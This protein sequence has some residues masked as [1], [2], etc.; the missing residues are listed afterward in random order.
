[1]HWDRRYNWPIAVFLLALLA[2]LVYFFEIRDH[3]IILYPQLDSD[4]YHQWAISI[5]E[6][7][8][9]GGSN[10]FFTSPFYAYFLAIIY[11][12]FSPD[13]DVIRLVQIVFG[14]LTCSL[15][16]LIGRK[17]F[18]DKAALLASLL[19]CCYGYFIYINLELLKNTLVV[20]N[21]TLG[22]YL[23]LVAHE[24]QG[25]L[26]W[27]VAG[28]SMGLAVINQPNILL[29]LPVFIFWIIFDKT[30]SPGRAQ[31]CAIFMCGV[32][33]TIA[34]VTVRNYIVERD[35][36]LVSSNGGFNFYL[37]NNPDTD[38]GLF[39]SK[40]IEADPKREESQ[41]RQFA[42][43]ALG[44]SLKSSEVSNY[45]FG[46]AAQFIADEPV[47]FLKLTFRKT[48]L[49]F[50]WYEIPD[51]IDFYFMK[52]YSVM[53]STP[54]LH[55][56]VLVP[57]AA[58]GLIFTR[59][60]RKKHMVFYAI[61]LIFCAST[62]LFL[63][64]ARYRLTIVPLLTLYAA[65]AII[66]MIQKFR[67]GAWKQV[68]F[69]FLLLVMLAYTCNR[70]ILQYPVQGSQRILADIY[71]KLGKYQQAQFEYRQVLEAFPNDVIL[72]QNYAVALDLAGMQEPAMV[73][74]RILT[75]YPLPNQQKARLYLAM[76][77]ILNKQGLGSPAKDAY[78]KAV[79]FD[80]EISD[81]SKWQ[82]LGREIPRE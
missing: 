32:L 4:S 7:N 47:S 46:K 49:F 33:L 70:T 22:I 40:F 15:T 59:R 80:K 11:K 1:M 28:L 24:R 62:I 21:V 74:Y 35:F 39:A 30:P 5:Y 71:A 78:A 66:E 2:R 27:G 68:L 19:L 53:L 77:I 57:F 37:A 6:G 50:N 51:N 26:L 42:E 81:I 17:L 8:W 52:R 31:K 12:L 16:F 9:L 10:A 64:F 67:K 72:R 63:P 43:D 41:N 82:Y 18:N 61:I 44:H 14:S 20:F 23:A 56:G 65:H 73:Q 45:W 54:F 13:H 79:M 55:F 36:V 69:S 48:L 29:L 76:A 58:L 60:A 25:W 3:P 75:G 38:G 34:P